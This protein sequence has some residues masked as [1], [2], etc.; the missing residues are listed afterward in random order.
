MRRSTFIAAG[1]FALSVYPLSAQEQNALSVASPIPD[2]ARFLLIQSPILAKLTFRVDRFTGDTWQLVITPEGNFTWQ[3]IKRI[4]LPD[5]EKIFGRVNYQI[6]LSGMLA[7]I[8][9]LMNTNTGASWHIT[10][11]SAGGIFWNPLK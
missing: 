8:T 4:S 9:V 11:D 2:S 3:Q 6:F 1:L 5:D 10:E 7:K